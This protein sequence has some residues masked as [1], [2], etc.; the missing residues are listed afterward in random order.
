MLIVRKER[1]VHSGDGVYCQLSDGYRAGMKRDFM[2]DM[3]YH[4]SPTPF[5][6]AKCDT[7][8]LPKEFC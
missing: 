7:V 3:H 6:L 1:H 4:K 8:L 2:S 5:V